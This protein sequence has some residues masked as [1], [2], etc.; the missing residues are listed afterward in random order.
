MDV[1][2]VVK[3]TGSPSVGSMIPSINAKIQQLYFQFLSDPLNEAQLLLDKKL[4]AQGKL[5]RYEASFFLLFTHSFH[6]RKREWRHF[7]R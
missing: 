4:I 7:W 2:S 3:T 5:E 1:S 6:R